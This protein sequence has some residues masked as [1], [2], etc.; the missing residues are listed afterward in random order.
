MS[1]SGP[2]AGF[3]HYSWKGLR[4][5]LRVSLRVL[6]LAFLLVFLVAVIGYFSLRASFNEERVRSIFVTELQDILSRP[7]Q[8]DKVLLTP[9]GVKLRGVRVIERMDVPGQHMLSSDTVLVTVKFSSLLRL[10]LDLGQVR[11]VAPYIQLV[12]DEAGHWNVADIFASTHTAQAMSVG[13]FSLPVSLGA[14]L[15]VIERGLVKVEDRFKNTSYRFENVDLRVRKFSM[16]RPFSFS[17]SCDNKN[18]FEGRAISSSWQVEGAAYLPE[19][20]LSRAYVR[21]QRVGVEVEGKKLRGSG[22]FIGLPPTEA[23]LE[24]SVPALGREDWRRWFGKEWEFALPESRWQAQAAFEPQRLIVRS[25][26][27]EGPDLDV[28]AQG[29][30][31]F[32]S[33]T[34]QA[35]I[36][37]P[38][39][40]LDRA[41]D[42]YPAWGRL[43][44][45][46]NMDVV[47]GVGGPWKRLQ[48]Q[49]V[50]LGISRAGGRFANLTVDRG[51]FRFNAW[52]NLDKVALT[53]TN[54]R[55]KIF[56]SPFSECSV[57]ARLDKG[58]LRLER[59]GLR[60]GE[61]KLALKARVRDLADP[62]EIAVTGSVD[63]LSWEEAQAL[64]A[65][66]A[67][68]VSTGP[69]VAAAA[70]S[71][72]WVRTF[73]YAIPKKFPDTIGHITISSVTHKN[74][75]FNNVD[76]LWDIRGVSQSLKYVSGD[77]R[78]S[79]GPGRVGDIPAVQSA[80]K[81]LSIIFLPFIYMHKM[82]NLSVFST[83]TA[84]PKTLDF[85]RIEGEYG[86]SQGVAST[87][88]FYVDSPQ[89]V[90]FA[91]GAADFG[92]ETVDMTILTRLTGYRDPLPEWWVDEMGRPA[93]GFRVKGDLNLPQLDPRLS[94]LAGDE[95]EKALEEARAKAKTRYA[96]L[97][98]LKEL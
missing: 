14:D 1:A 72:P 21:A 58:D 80:N 12:R 84:Y 2:K 98:K 15:T 29:R 61:S 76:L 70:A 88:L 35:E 65:E 31:D 50:K 45:K 89:M 78:V 71:R 96:A 75:S 27:V 54:A 97:D 82:N 48:L 25:L 55:G 51:D 94:K 57:A 47:L 7:V 91:D 63:S 33:A 95:I 18:E 42:M 67:A 11:F 87:H 66:I 49:R 30:V 32:A 37:A 85:S 39:L 60:F 36:A 73:K 53:V 28:S 17:V 43:G 34:L 41:A 79:F 69:A 52:E 38:A 83:A 74:F 93:I 4:Y 22:G 26:H 56:S 92:K 90:A 9:H 3:W 86:L 40:A 16:D 64:V 44:L 59:L 24:A 62:K 68:K 8:I 20:D 46:G 6:G 23:D 5:L 10:R 81:F 13:R 77:V 19:D